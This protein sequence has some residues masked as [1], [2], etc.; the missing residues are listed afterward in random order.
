VPAVVNALYVLTG[1]P[2]RKL[3]IVLG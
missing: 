2:I 3:P 1:K